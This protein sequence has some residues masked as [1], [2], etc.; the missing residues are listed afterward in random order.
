M[1]KRLALLLLLAPLPLVAQNAA[2][3]GYCN[4]GG[5][6]ALVSGL[7]STNYFQGI[8]IGCTITPY[9][10]GTVTLAPYSLTPTGSPQTG[11]FTANT[12]GSLNPGGWLIYAPTGVGIDIVASGGIPPNSYAQPVTILT[13]FTPGGGGGTGGVTVVTGTGPIVVNPNVGAVNVSCPTCAF[14]STGTDNFAAMFSG[15]PANE[16]V[17]FPMSYN[18]GTST[19]TVLPSATGSTTLGLSGAD[20]SA[21][22]LSVSSTGGVFNILAPGGEAVSSPFAMNVPSGGQI[23]FTALSGGRLDVQ[24]L[25]TQCFFVGQLNF[26]AECISKQLGGTIFNVDYENTGGGKLSNLFNPTTAGFI[27][28]VVSGY[29]W[30][31]GLT[32]NN[33]TAGAVTCSGAVATMSFTGG[34]LSSNQPFLI[35]A[36]FSP[37][38]FENQVI[39]GATVSGSSVSFTPTGGCT[40]GSGGAIHVPSASSISNFLSADYSGVMHFGTGPMTNGPSTDMLRLSAT[41][42]FFPQIA[43]GGTQCLQISSIGLVTPTGSGCG[44]GGSGITALTGDVTASGSGSVAATLATVNSGP[45]S[46]GDATHV[47]QVTTNGKGLVTAQAAVA[48]TGGGSGCTPSGTTGL[49]LWYNGTTC[50]LAT[51]IS[52][53]NIAG[54]LSM[55]GTETGSAGFRQAVVVN[56]NGVNI[57]AENAATQNTSGVLAGFTS[58]VSNSQFFTPNPPEIDAVNGIVVM[59]ASALSGSV[60]G[61]A[62]RGSTIINNS[63]S[64]GWGALFSCNDVPG[65]TNTECWGTELDLNVQDASTQIEGVLVDGSWN[66]TP[67][68]SVAF[69]VQKPVG[70]SGAAWQ[71]GF[72]SYPGASIIAFEAGPTANTGSTLASQT[73]Q[74]D[75]VVSSVQQPSTIGADNTGAFVLTPFAALTN[76]V[77]ALHTSGDITDVGLASGGTQ[78]V[79][80]NTAGKLIGL[81]SA[82][83]A[84]SPLTTKGD[85]FTFSTVPARLPVGTNGFVLTADSTQTDGIKW[86]A[87]GSPTGPTVRGYSL[88][89]TNVSTATITIPAGSTV[90]DYGLLFIGTAYA[91]TSVSGSWTNI[92]TRTGSGLNGFTY[93][94]HLTSGDVATGTITIVFTGTFDQVVSLVVFAG[95]T[96]GLRELQALRSGPSSGTGVAAKQTLLSTGT[97]EL[98]SD[99]IIYFAAART[100]V[101]DNVLID[102]TNPNYPVPPALAAD[103]LMVGQL[104]S[105]LSPGGSTSSTFTYDASPGIGNSATVYSTY[106]VMAVVEQ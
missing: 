37:S 53:P 34:S 39:T 99:L 92:D 26:P 94:T 80:A 73:L 59:N 15:T 43:P 10:T 20:G 104:G 91:I 84:S 2:V 1:L 44:S 38:G 69:K 71:Q 78:C 67:S 25:G 72:A 6:Q 52:Y 74:F 41:Q 46:C 12:Y 4:Q 83:G 58:A 76:I 88:Q 36:S 103:T 33:L 56:I 57:A 42:V 87:S 3:Q 102:G 55:A 93:S 54:N 85:L 106:S 86:A 18:A 101:M 51:G 90:G 13:A 77:G 35:D 65:Q 63:G 9:L 40:T 89:N 17:N 31:L 7:A 64:A 28:P 48:I 24:S 97:T 16:L 21:V 27:Y 30:N 45:G 68:S 105:H 29:E 98:N 47:C 79:E 70:S 14:T 61:I 96:S 11:P 100:P 66:A 81:G 60:P 62:V 8:V 95:A 5:V 22:S 50:A 32:Y 82:C 23:V 19:V 49:L 75:S